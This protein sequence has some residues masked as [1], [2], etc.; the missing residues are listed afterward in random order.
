MTVRRRTPILRSLEVETLAEKRQIRMVCSTESIGRDKLI[1]VSRGF[2]LRQYRD[3]PIWLWM[4]DPYSPVARSV[5]IG[6]DDRERLVSLVQFP[7]AGVSPKSDEV[8]G[9]VSTGVVNAASTGFNEIASEPIDPTD[10][11]SGWRVTEA[12][13]LEMSFVSI[14]A[15]PNA[16]ALGRAAPGS[17]SGVPNGEIMRWIGTE[18]GEHAA[19]AFRT[20]MFGV[21]LTCC[22]AADL[23]VVDAD[24]DAAAAADRVFA[25]AGFDGETPD[26]HL[27]QRAFACLDTSAPTIKNSYR[28]VFADVVDG[29]LRANRTGIASVSLTI[30]NAGLPDDIKTCVR[31]LVDKYKVPDETTDTTD[32]I[33]A[34]SMPIIQAR[35]RTRSIYD[36]GALA[37]TLSELGWQHD[38]AAWEADVEKD[39]SKVPAMLADAMRQVA[40]AL[41]AMTAE[42]VAE[43]L[44]R[45][46]P[47][48]ATAALSSDDA[49]D[50][51]RAT[52]PTARGFLVGWYRARSSRAALE[53]PSQ[54]SLAR[55]AQYHA[56]MAK[57]V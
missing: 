13:L 9:W 21:S 49:V 57:V 8:W 16:L 4:H 33:G 26:V 45:L 46:P 37:Y 20:R 39:A 17:L 24:W 55:R 23:P 25:L 47:P 43:L 2:D 3:N 44:A 31:A 40:D 22:G 34:R 18:I 53:R 56:R 36:I 5:E 51:E 6:I 15:D 11:R 29:E 7:P 54:A 12:E 50:L 19:A 52:A 35:M 48:A 27:A 14:P 28:M 42:E 32:N 30:D 10:T 41:V 38:Q 1:L